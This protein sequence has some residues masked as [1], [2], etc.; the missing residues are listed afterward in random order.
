MHTMWNVFTVLAMKEY[1][2]SRGTAPVVLN[3]G[4]RWRWVVDFTRQLLCSREGTL[5]S[6][7]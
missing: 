1:K 4:T 3:V 6:V 5:V 2:G 7:E